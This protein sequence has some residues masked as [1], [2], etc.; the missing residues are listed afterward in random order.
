MLSIEAEG[1]GDNF[2]Q[3]LHN[4]S[5]LTRAEFSNKINTEAYI[6]VDIWLLHAFCI[7]GDSYVSGM[8]DAGVT[9][10]LRIWEYGPQPWWCFKLTLKWYFDGNP[11]WCMQ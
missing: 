10:S 6:V 2:L 8:Q 3:D 7:F 4:S 11:Y 1:Q 9:K 5:H